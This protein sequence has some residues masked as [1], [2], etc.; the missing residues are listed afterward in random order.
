MVIDHFVC[1]NVI[2]MRSAC[3]TPSDLFRFLRKA[4]DITYPNIK[5]GDL[6][7]EKLILGLFCG[8]LAVCIILNISVLYAL[9]FGFFLFL[10]Y[11]KGR[12]YSWNHL[13]HMSLS[14]LGTTKNILEVFVL[15]GMLTALWRA[16]GTV[17]YIICEAVRFI[18]PNTFLLMTFILN[19]AISVLTGTALGTAATMGVICMTM[20]ASLGIDPLLAGGAVLSGVYFGDR[21]SPVSTSALLVAELTHTNI[22]DNIHNMIPRAILPFILSCII[23]GILGIFSS[24][25]GTAPDLWAVFAPEFDFHICMLLPAAAILL[26]S[27]LRINVKVTMGVSILI[28]ILICLF[29]IRIDP[30]QLAGYMLTGYKASD[31]EIS[32]MLNGGGIS[33]MLQVIMIVF[34]SSSYAGIFR[35]T[36]L[37]DHIKELI[38]GLSRRITSFGAVLTTSII[39]GMITCSQALNIMITYQ[40]CEELGDDKSELAID[41]EDTAVIISPLVPW[42]IACSAP[43][44]SAGA[45]TFAVIAACFL[46]LLPATHLLSCLRKMRRAA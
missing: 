30:L 5:E 12:G 46:Y 3:F 31:P 14:G 15:I 32:A 43:M 38:T 29:Y 33:S 4:G 20:S 45:P 2:L 34:I 42:S 11:G 17:P 25:T 24:G 7:L 16:C 39:C 44:S 1:Y 36:G 19:C 23:Y 9:I 37:L 27:L 35:E 6:N 26:L 13:L 28:S 8:G 10:A 21:C 22:F 40:L 18:H 41:L